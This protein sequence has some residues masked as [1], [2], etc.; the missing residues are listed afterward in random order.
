MGFDNLQV[1]LNHKVSAVA[2]LL[3]N[4]EIIPKGVPWN[5]KN[6]FLAMSRDRKFIKKVQLLRTLANAEH[7]VNIKELI[8]AVDLTPST[9]R[10]EIHT[11]NDE[12]KTY[13]DI[14][15]PK[16]GEYLLL[17]K[18]NTSIEA[19]VA[20]LIKE[21]L[22][23]KIVKSLFNN[24]CFDLYD[25]LDYFCVSRSTYLRTVKSMNE[26]LVNFNIFIET[27]TLRFKGKEE[28]IRVFLFE[29]F[30]LLGDTQVVSE[31]ANEDTALFIGLIQENIPTPLY[32]NYFRISLWLSIAKIRWENGCYLETQ[33][34]DLEESVKGSLFFGK[35]S[36]VIEYLHFLFNTVDSLPKEEYI[37]AFITSLHCLSYRTPDRL[38]S[39][40][41]DYRYI[42]CEHQPEVR[43]EIQ[44]IIRKFMPNVGDQEDIFL[45]IEGFLI[46]SHFLSSMSPNYEVITSDYRDF[47]KTQYENL[48]VKWLMH[49]SSVTKESKLLR[50]KKIEDLAVCLVSL[51][52]SNSKVNSVK[53]LKVLF[54]IQGHAGLD[55]YIMERAKLYITQNMDVEFF[56]NQPISLEDMDK[57]GADVV[58]TNYN[59]FDYKK[60]PSHYIHMST[61]PTSLDWKILKQLFDSLSKESLDMQIDDSQFH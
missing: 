17:F 15:S 42:N 56:I 18:S 3:F 12:L 37:W 7:S 43:W 4:P 24:D 23:F 50:Y 5:M 22:T 49:L 8:T 48:Y 57:S 29:F 53:P 33:F 60:M 11:L 10:T 55:E 31:T 30:A 52:L 34:V 51:F 14:S 40:P 16:Q 47:I 46:N 58:V 38:S 21:A 27:S 6:L 2:T 25:A 35:F 36:K 45:K 59:A 61:I 1:S 54:A 19:I 32:Y 28:D 13:I 44:S 26:V 41:Y 9:I 39:I 20:E